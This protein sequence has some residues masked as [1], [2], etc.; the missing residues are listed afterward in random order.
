MQRINIAFYGLKPWVVKVQ[1]AI[2]FL[3]KFYF[4]QIPRF[5]IRFCLTCVHYWDL[6]YCNE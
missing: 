2:I 4:M 6:V 1:I 3:A 5:L